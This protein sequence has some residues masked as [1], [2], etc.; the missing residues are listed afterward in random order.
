[1]ENAVVL[2]T[3]LLQVHVGLYLYCRAWLRSSD[4]DKQSTCEL[5][6]PPSRIRSGGAG[7]LGQVQC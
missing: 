4:K 7:V 3:V 6:A 1:M 5:L 2:P